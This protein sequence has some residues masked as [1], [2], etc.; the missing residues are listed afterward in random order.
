MV[1]NCIDQE[2][3]FPDAMKSCVRDQ[4]DGN[5]LNIHGIPDNFVGNFAPRVTN[6]FH[7]LL[8]SWFMAVAHYYV[9]DKLWKG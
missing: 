4:F 8:Y 2:K 5:L 1:E 3:E 7:P 9:W 6:Y